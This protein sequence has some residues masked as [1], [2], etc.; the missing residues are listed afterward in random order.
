MEIAVLIMVVCM[1]SGQSLVNKIYGKKCGLQNFYIFT[2][3]CC[4]A[5]AVVFAVTADGS[6]LPNL[7]ILPYSA[8][9][10]IAFGATLLLEA[11]AVKLGPL[12]LSSLFLSYSLLIP[13]VAGIFLWRETVGLNFAIGIVCL[14]VSIFLIYFK[15]E[16]IKIT[17]KWVACVFTAVVCNGTCSVIQR[18]QQEHFNNE[19]SSQF[20]ITALMLSAVFMLVCG[21]RKSK[22]NI[23]GIVKANFL[24]GAVAGF[25]NG[26]LN[27]G[28]I[29]LNGMKFP[30]TVM[31]PIISVGS[32][33]MSFAFSYIFFKEKLSAIQLAGAAVGILAIVM[34]CI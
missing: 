5:A 10:A 31:F 25:M 8:A 12:S 26:L 28:V 23:S 17:P 7:K 20:M 33:I 9:F 14:I 34:F 13:T 6:L 16:G 19:F 18:V 24:Y 21:F 3:L 22:G 15:A 30:A 1:W 27:F 32:I 4:L 29:V 11:L 2:A